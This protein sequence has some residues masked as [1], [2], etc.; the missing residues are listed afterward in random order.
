MNPVVF[1]SEVGC[2]DIALLP[3][4]KLRQLVAQGLESARF[5]RSHPAG[6]R[7]LEKLRQSC[8]PGEKLLGEVLSHQLAH[9]LSAEQEMGRYSE[10]QQRLL[11]SG[12]VMELR[13]WDCIA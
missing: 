3:A 12:L 5:Y 8:N 11:L 1:V 4:G 7:L 13:H 2:L 10:E 6:Y 9:G